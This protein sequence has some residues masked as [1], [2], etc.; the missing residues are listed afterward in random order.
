MF[1][2]KVQTGIQAAGFWIFVCRLFMLATL[3]SNPQEESSW[4]EAG[5]EIRKRLGKSMHTMHAF[6]HSTFRRAPLTQMVQ[7]QPSDDTVGKCS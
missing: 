7:N 3:W 1:Y 4:F 5:E 6:A 2:E